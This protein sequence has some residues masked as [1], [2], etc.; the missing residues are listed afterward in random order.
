VAVFGTA[1]LSWEGTS[2]ELNV[3]DLWSIAAAATSAMFILRL[4]SASAAVSDSG[5]LNSACLWVV[6]MASLLWTM[7][8]GVL[9]TSTLA[10]AIPHVWDNVLFVM[11]SHPFALVY[12]S[13]VT[14]ALANYIQTRAQRNVTAERASVIYAMDPVYGAVFSYWLLGERLASTG[15][16]GAGLITIA[17]AT[18]AFLDLGKAQTTSEEGEKEE[19]NGEATDIQS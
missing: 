14:T 16:L 11:Q 1:L 2:L 6:T 8:Q 5:A 19:T 18:N 4:E 17:A 13:G 10:E 12:L 9:D 15:I 7:G 3:G